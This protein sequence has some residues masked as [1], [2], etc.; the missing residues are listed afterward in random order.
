MNQKPLSLQE[1]LNQWLTHLDWADDFSLCYIFAD[2][3]DELDR[4]LG[5]LTGELGAPK[6]VHPRKAA[7]LK[8]LAPD[9]PSLDTADARF[10]WLRANAQPEETAWMKARENFIA[11]FNE[12]RDPVRQAHKCPLVLILPADY[13]EEARNLAP[14]LWSVRDRTLEVAPPAV[15]PPEELPKLTKKPPGRLAYF[16]KEP[17]PYGEPLD[18]APPEEQLPKSLLE[19]FRER[20][21]TLIAGPG[22]GAVAGLPNLDKAMQTLQRRFEDAAELDK[23]QT[24]DLKGFLKRNEY[25]RAAKLLRDLNPVLFRDVLQRAYDPKPDWGSIQVHPSWFP[26]V[27]NLKL[28][29]ILTTGFDLLLSDGLGGDRRRLT[30]QDLIFLTSLDQ[31]SR[32]FLL[33]YFGRVDRIGSVVLSLDQ[34]KEHRASPAPQILEELVRQDHLLLVG[35]GPD[36][37]WIARL[38]KLNASLTLLTCEASSAEDVLT[39]PNPG[40]KP[41]PR[42]EDKAL[43]I[44]FTNLARQL[45]FD[46][47][48]KAVPEPETAPP[49]WLEVTSGF[50]STLAPCGSA[51]RKGF[52]RGD[53]VT[54]NL[55][56]QGCTVQRRTTAEVLH[57]LEPDGDRFRAVLIL[58]A[59]G[60]GKSTIVK[61]VG[62][63]L[64]YNSNYTVL[65]ASHPEADPFKA[66][67][68]KKGPLVLL[69]DNAQNLNKVENLL[70]FARGRR[71]PTRLVM[72]ARTNEWNY[73]QERRFVGDL[74][75][76]LRVVQVERLEEGEAENLAQ[77]ILDA[78]AS[79]AEQDRNR[80]AAEI[81][82]RTGGFLLAAMLMATHGKPLEEILEDVVANI[83]E[84]DEGP[85]LLEA[86]GLVV[87]I[88]QMSRSQKKHFFCHILL[89]LE[90]LGITKKQANR[91]FLRLEG[92]MRLRAR[93]GYRIETRNPIIA[94]ALHP[95]LFEKPP[96]YL[97]LMDLHRRLMESARNIA[98]ES[99]KSTMMN[100]LSIVPLDH[101][102]RRDIEGAR[103]LYT[104]AT[105]LN[106]KHAP[107]WQAWAVMEQKQNN[108]GEARRLFKRAIYFDPEHVP[109]LQAWARLEQSEGRPGDL[110]TPYTARWLFKT[111]LDLDPQHIQTLQAWGMLER[112]AHNPGDARTPYTARWLFKTA[113]D[114][115]PQNVQILQA[116]GMLERD[117]HNPGDAETP[118]TARWLFKTALDLDPHNGSSWHTW[119][120]LEI[121]EGCFD[122]AR[123]MLAE[124]RRLAPKSHW[125]ALEK[126]LQQPHQDLRELIA[127]GRLDEAE[128]RLQKAFFENP[129]D[130]TLVQLRKDLMAAR[131][132][133]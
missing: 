21:V 98:A 119:I 109:S 99:P 129:D 94:R 76:T 97:D 88:E 116:W 100:F 10:I 95:I 46:L 11:R 83:A 24:G 93:G 127:A 86:M 128:T 96:Y 56:A 5:R 12:I 54:W 15:A 18:T 91:I 45:G 112:D 23:Q 50:L 14:D 61:Q 114:L 117:A 63:E 115:D 92:E 69:I 42:S 77:L 44:W 89:F 120:E 1:N 68:S 101:E 51:T 19:K 57:Q 31:L 47:K 85:R 8:I 132:R 60:E 49:D 29:R 62:L 2:D 38:R 75:G 130:A 103:A 73:G 113:L 16:D 48:P 118:Y 33:H 52:Y 43:N 71:A 37:P 80:L 82:S 4:I 65:E 102:K 13:K 55:V 27:R 26:A 36:D 105:E 39:L 70:R 111:A 78:G 79:R 34:V 32:P 35:Y 122:E 126:K 7:D 67:K 20:R 133:E 123:R 59:G 74:R 81:K 64:V 131:D 108:I 25:Q 107:A 104:L 72:A 3:G 106:P 9:L 30:W 90:V 40:G 41:G 110:E 84:M 28:R 22:I 53:A 124:A 6:I 125:D 17:P 87:T 66:L 58:A 121:K